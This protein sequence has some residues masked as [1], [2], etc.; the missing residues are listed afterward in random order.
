MQIIFGLLYMKKTEFCL[1][2]L[3]AGCMVIS[4]DSQGQ[5]K[6]GWAAAP[7]LVEGNYED[8]PV[9]DKMQRGNW[10]TGGSITGGYAGGMIR[11][12]YSFGTTAQLGYLVAKRL[13]G[14]VQIS[15]GS[16]HFDYKL[17]SAMATQIIKRHFHSLTPEIFGRYYITSYKVKP[18][19]HVSAGPKWIWGMQQR[20]DSKARDM[21][22]TQFT[23][24]IAGGFSWLFKS[25]WAIEAMYQHQ[26]TTDSPLADGNS[27][28]PLRIGVNFFLD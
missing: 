5:S 14:G 6:R 27:R 9:G 18:F 19:I 24:S 21:Q 3:M 22:Q 17:P 20:V 23:S 12:Q 10:T 28:T 8:T 25:K 15:Y 1:L 26:I 4:A 11:K 7:Y 13:V 2:I 16:D